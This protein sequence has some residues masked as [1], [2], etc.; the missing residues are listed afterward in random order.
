MQGK[1]D[2]M[3]DSLVFK[4]NLGGNPL[5]ELYCVLD[6]HGGRRVADFAAEVG[7]TEMG[8]I[9]ADESEGWLN[10]SRSGARK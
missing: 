3:E 5:H 7:C 4:G 8:T 2:G 1:R 10:E 6:G 9:V